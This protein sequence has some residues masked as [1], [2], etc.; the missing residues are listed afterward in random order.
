MTVLY[1]VRLKAQSRSVYLSYNT[2]ESL[3]NQKDL[4]KAQEPSILVHNPMAVAIETLP[5]SHVLQR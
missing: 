5:M 1:V 3:F 4:L 2:G